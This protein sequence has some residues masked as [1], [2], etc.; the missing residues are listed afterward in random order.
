MATFL[1]LVVALA[2]VVTA[3]TLAVVGGGDREVLPD[4]PPDALHAPLPHE[5]AVTARDVQELRF[6]PALRG[7]RMDDVDE[8]LTRL[9]HE[10]AHRDERIASLEA[11]LGARGS[12]GA[13][14]LAVRDGEA[15]ERPGDLLVKREEQPAAPAVEEKPDETVADAE[16]DA[17]TEAADADDVDRSGGHDGRPEQQGPAAPGEAR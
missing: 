16:S 12:A 9:A 13:T 3:T 17:D 1:I 6:A 2:V 10:L 5:R 4:A 14:R 11:A 15:T 7:Y 8:V